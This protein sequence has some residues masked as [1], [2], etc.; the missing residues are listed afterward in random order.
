MN[1]AKSID[2]INVQARIGWTTTSHSG[3]PVPVWAKGVGSAQ[4]AGRQDNTDIP[5]KICAAMGVQF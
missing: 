3:G 1:D 5:K 2:S 4:F